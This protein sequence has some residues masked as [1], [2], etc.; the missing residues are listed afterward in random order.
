VAKRDV[1]FATL[2]AE[3]E[4][5]LHAAGFEGKGRAWRRCVGDAIQIMDVADNKYRDACFVDL[6]IHYW[7]LPTQA[8]Q[9]V[10][11]AIDW[12][13]C[14]FQTRLVSG[15]SSWS[16]GLTAE[17]ARNNA[18]A[19]IAAVTESGL[20]YFA[21]WSALPGPFAAIEPDDL[22]TRQTDLEEIR[23]NQRVRPFTRELAYPGHLEPVRAARALAHIHAHLGHADRAHAFASL[24]RELAGLSG[25]WRY[26]ERGSE[27][28]LYRTNEGAWAARTVASPRVVEIGMWALRGVEPDVEAGTWR[29]EIMT[30][31]VGAAHCTLRLVDER[32]LE[33]VATK[34]DRTVRMSWIRVA[35][36]ADTDV[37]A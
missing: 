34:G 30:T 20:P 4:P 32:T 10:S 33:V 21:T 15:T 8:R 35:S 36:P 24:A 19:L 22:R 1:F 37:G 27:V 23:R 7:W 14:E 31:Q 13:A 18:R 25:R 12:H 5:L 2:R 16:Y 29:G 11:D 3:L 6:G 9:P 26:D 28:E 17:I